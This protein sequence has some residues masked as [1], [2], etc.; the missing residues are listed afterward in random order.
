VAARRVAIVPHTHWDREWYQP[1]QAFRLRLVELLDELLPRLEADGYGN[2]VAVPDDAKAL[3]ARMRAYVDAL[4]RL[5]H[6]AP[7]CSG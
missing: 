5:L 7:P 4:G 2:G 3:L 6:R 1:F